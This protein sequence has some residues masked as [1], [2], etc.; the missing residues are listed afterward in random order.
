MAL[1]FLRFFVAFFLFMFVFIALSPY[2]EGWR[3]VT[4]NRFL[5]AKISSNGRVTYLVGIYSGA[6]TGIWEFDETLVQPLRKQNIRRTIESNSQSIRITPVNVKNLEHNSYKVEFIT[7]PDNE[8]PI[9]WWNGPAG[10]VD[11]YD[12]ITHMREASLGP[13]GQSVK[14]PDRP[15]DRFDVLHKESRVQYIVTPEGIYNLWERLP[16]IRTKLV[17]RGSCEGFGQ[18]YLRHWKKR[19]ILIVNENTL[20]VHD[21]A[22]GLLR[23][24]KLPEIV[25]ALLNGGDVSFILFDNGKMA[26]HGSNKSWNKKTILLL[27][28]DGT[29]ERQ[30]DY[31]IDEI[32]K[33]L[34][35]GA[36]RTRILFPTLIPPIP[37][38]G[39]M[40][41]LALVQSIALSL[42]L[43]TVV[44][45]RQTRREGRGKLRVAWAV[46]TFIFGLLGFVTYLVAY[47]DRRFEPCPDCRRLRPIVEEICPHCSAPWSAHKPLGIEIIDTA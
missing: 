10:Q 15:E 21:T 18:G 32:N 9:I 38:S 24:I 19:V 1:K 42:V 47:W 4:Q 3:D 25:S 7:G 14:A 12:H 6:R 26:I 31:D 22:G 16:D 41:R 43:A 28:E 8:G 2:L 45:W 11:L 40:E 39:F 27:E 46:F 20:S 36:G 29:L 23:D 35:E 33:T 44:L 5:D 34:N 37:V 13:S 30:V 17:Y